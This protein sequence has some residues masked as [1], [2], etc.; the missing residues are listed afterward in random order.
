MTIRDFNTQLGSEKSSLFVALYRLSRIED[1]GSLVAQMVADPA[2][3]WS[4]WDTTGSV[5]PAVC[6]ASTGA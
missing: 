5:P 6:S 2:A 4:F 1:L 3:N